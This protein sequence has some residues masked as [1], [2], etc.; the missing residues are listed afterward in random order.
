MGALHHMLLIEP[1]P[2]PAS[3]TLLGSRPLGPGGM[4]QV[5]EK[6]MSHFPYQQTQ[7]RVS[8][9]PTFSLPFVR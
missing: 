9:G 5:Q 7:G 4:E 2:I 3:T 8:D 1:I 6:L